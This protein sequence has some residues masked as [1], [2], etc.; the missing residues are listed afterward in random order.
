MLGGSH[1]ARTRCVNYAKKH[2]AWS[3]Q[4][5][6][7]AKWI[8]QAKERWADRPRYFISP[9]Y[10]KKTTQENATTAAGPTSVGLRNGAAT[11]KRQA[12][13]TEADRPRRPRGRPPA[14]SAPVRTDHGSRDISQMLT[15]LARQ[16]VETAMV[17]DDD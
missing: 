13:P 5:P 1:T 7:R 14:S 6:V 2:P 9:D 4:C 16:S 12:E 17:L 8:A 11:R 10:S 3:K 15:A